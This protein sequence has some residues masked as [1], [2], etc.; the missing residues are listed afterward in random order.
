MSNN[1]I[2]AETILRQL[3]G[4]RFI[5]FTGAKHFTMITNGVQFDLPR[6]AGKVNRVQ[7]TLNGKDLYDMRFLK[8]SLPRFNKKTMTLSEYKEKEIKTYNDVYFTELQE[9]FTETT[10]LYTHF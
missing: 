6:N 2:I 7:I 10:Q 9:F 1:A 3:G 4:K 8:V 5:A